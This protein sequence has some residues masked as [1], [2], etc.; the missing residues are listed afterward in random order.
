MINDGNGK[1]TERRENDM[2][3]NSEKQEKTIL[4]F[5]F[6]NIDKLVEEHI[7]KKYKK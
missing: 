3:M 4:G 1:R 6:I 7:A 5:F 2:A